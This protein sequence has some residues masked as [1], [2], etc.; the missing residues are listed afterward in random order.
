MK[1][2]F[3]LERRNCD[4]RTQ[5]AIKSTGTDYSRYKVKALIPDQYLLV[6]AFWDREWYWYLGFEAG[7]TYQTP[8]KLTEN[9]T[10]ITEFSIAYKA[11]RD[12]NY[13][14]YR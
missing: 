3:E 1:S 6:E 12:S 14:I 5:V 7:G 8:A 13:R 9:G 4:V 11:D 2:V 10:V